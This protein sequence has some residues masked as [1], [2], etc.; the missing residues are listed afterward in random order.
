MVTVELRVLV[1]AHRPQ[2]FSRLFVDP[3]LRKSAD[4]KQLS[5]LPDAL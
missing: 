3:E 1:Q 5:V 4:L 2:G